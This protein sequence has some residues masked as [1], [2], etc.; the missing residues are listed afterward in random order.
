MEEDRVQEDKSAE[1]KDLVA[2]AK[3]ATVTLP[4]LREKAVDVDSCVPYEEVKIKPTDAYFSSWMECCYS[5]GSSG[6]S[7][8]MLFCVDCGEGFHSFCANA[9]IHCMEVSSAAGWRCP[10]IKIRI[11]RVN[12]TSSCTTKLLSGSLDCR[13]CTFETD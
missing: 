10:K 12:K 7:D 9:P 3:V 11:C 1:K 13:K 5:C 8:T 6:A 2:G 4:S